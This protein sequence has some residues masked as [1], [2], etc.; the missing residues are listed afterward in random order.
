MVLTKRDHAGALVQ[1]NWGVFPDCY[2]L[3]SSPIFDNTRKGVQEKKKGSRK[4]GQA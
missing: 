1:F 3:P 4:R 2:G